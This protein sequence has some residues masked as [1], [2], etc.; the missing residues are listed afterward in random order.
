VL[1]LFADILEG[2]PTITVH[3]HPMPS[4]ALTKETPASCWYK[5]YATLPIRQR[6]GRVLKAGR[7]MQRLTLEK[8]SGITGMRK[9]QLLEIEQGFR[10]IEPAEA[11][12]LARVLA[13]DP[14][15][16]HAEA[17]VASSC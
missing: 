7:T 3:E 17:S 8:L 6:A 12:V 16:F 10:A 5:R 2:I 14:Q 4:Q 11:D 13:I 15:V 1:E 9:D